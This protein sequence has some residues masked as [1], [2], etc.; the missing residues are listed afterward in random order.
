MYILCVKLC[1]ASDKHRDIIPLF[2]LSTALMNA[3]IFGNVSAIIQRLYSGLLPLIMCV[4]VTCDMISPV[5]S[6]ADVCQYLWQRQCHHPT[7]VLGHGSLPLTDAES[8]GIHS[9][10]SDP[11]PPQTAAGGIL[12]ARLVLHERHRHEP[13]NYG[14]RSALA[15]P[16]NN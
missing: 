10:P 15:Y 8:E 7:P 16:C 13:G 5:V 6:S 14:D 4:C 1:F 3:S 9:L 12:P 2:R 11:E